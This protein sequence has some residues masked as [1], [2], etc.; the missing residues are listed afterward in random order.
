MFYIEREDEKGMPKKVPFAEVQLLPLPMKNLVVVWR[1][2]A[3]R[4]E[5]LALPDAPDTPGPRQA[6]LVNLVDRKLALNTN[7]NTQV[8]PAGESLTVSAEGKGVGIKI[9]LEMENSE[10][11]KLAAMNAI[12][13]RPSTRVNVLIAESNSLATAPEDEGKEIVA[14][15]LSLL[16]ITDTIANP[17][18]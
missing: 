2:S 7:G 12:R 17:T 3:G 16:V 8:I 6:R 18:E 4:F 1:N 13:V 11:W 9:A 5:A 15:P 14:K 10:G